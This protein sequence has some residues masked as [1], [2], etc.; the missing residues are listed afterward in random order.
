MVRVQ[1]LDVK[2]VT[3]GSMNLTVLVESVMLHSQILL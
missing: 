3:T 1:S 2:R